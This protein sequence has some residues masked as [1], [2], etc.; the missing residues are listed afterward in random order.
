MR[1]TNSLFMLAPAMLAAAAFTS[2]PAMA[3]AK[4]HVPFNFM[5]AGQRCPAGDYMV[6]SANR[7]SSVTLEGPA[8]KMFFLTGPG[9]PNPLDMHVIIS[10]DREGQNYLL[11]SVQYG[12]KITNRLDKPSMEIIPSANQAA[13]AE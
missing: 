12:S 1:Y 5:A 9:E 4:L 7:G 10:F 8:G 6:R 13:G 2:Q 11:R 3:A